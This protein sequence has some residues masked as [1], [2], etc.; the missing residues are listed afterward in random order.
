MLTNNDSVIFDIDNTL[1]DYDICHNMAIK[2][3]IETISLHSNIDY[4]ICLNAYNKSNSSLKHGLLNN[5]AT[6]HSKL[7]SFKLTLEELKIKMDYDVLDYIYWNIFIDQIRPYDN[8]IEFLNVL[9][10]YK[11]NLYVLSNYTLKHQIIKLKTLG[12]YDYFDNIIT[13]EEIGIEKPDNRTFDYCKNKIMSPSPIIMIGDS[14][15]NDVIGAVN[16]GM[17]AYWYNNKTN[18]NKFEKDKYNTFH[19]YSD[20][21][22]IIKEHE[23]KD[24]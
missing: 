21:I 4:D 16:S 14:F 8:V 15:S 12:M 19:N 1:Y 7:L 6:S 24:I 2:N 9:K 20:L 18:E 17:I 5:T 10:N 22:N 13:S 3:I 11:Y 23:N